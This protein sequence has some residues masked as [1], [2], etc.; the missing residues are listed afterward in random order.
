MGVYLLR[1]DDLVDVLEEVRRMDREE[2]QKIQA[3]V[4]ASQRFAARY[5]TL[6]SEMK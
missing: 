4:K 3:M 5:L 6:V 2:P 1:R